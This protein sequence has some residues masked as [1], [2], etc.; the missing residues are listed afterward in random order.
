[1]QF[2]GCLECRY[3]MEV[4]ADA[5]RQH[6]RAISRLQAAAIRREQELAEALQVL[7]EYAR[8][9]RKRAVARAKRHLAVHRVAV[10][11]RCA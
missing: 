10:L 5:T 1:M 6:I 9:A 3:F 7:V 11:N 2:K 8:K 4:A